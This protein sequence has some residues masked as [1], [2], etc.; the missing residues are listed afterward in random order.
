MYDSLY[1]I[2][3]SA[4]TTVPSAA[5]KPLSGVPAEDFQ[6]TRITSY[7]TFCVYALR[8]CVG[9]SM[10]KERDRQRERERERVGDDLISDVSVS[11]KK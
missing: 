11:Q 6:L 8:M 3:V 4:Q 1:N 2:N 10:C 9:M 5:C 7:V